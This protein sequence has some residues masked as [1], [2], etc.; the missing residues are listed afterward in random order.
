LAQAR[1]CKRKAQKSS[2]GAGN[3]IARNCALAR[4][5]NACTEIQSFILQY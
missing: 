5:A 1:T 3:R 2:S 4:K